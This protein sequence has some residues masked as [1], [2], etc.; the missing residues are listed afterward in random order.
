VSA[1]DGYGT[2]LRVAGFPRA[3][4]G[5]AVQRTGGQMLQVAIVLFVLARFHSPALAGLTVFLE[6]MPGLLISPL[7]GALLD[8]YGRVRLMLL[9]F[10][11]AAISLALIA[12]L[13]LAGHLAV[14]ALL[15]LVTISSLTSILSV[16]GIRSLF[17]LMVPKELWDRANGLDSGL[18]AVTAIVGPPL[19]AFIVALSGPETALLATAIAFAL[20]AAVMVGL[21]EPAPPERERRSIWREAYE[22]LRYVVGHPT[23]RGLA[24]SI[25]LSNIGAGG[26]LVI[27]LPVLLLSRL[28]TGTATVGWVFGVFGV[29][30]LISALAFGRMNTEG[31]ERP[32]LAWSM[33]TLA[34]S[35]LALAVAGALWVVFAATIFAGLFIGASDVSL[36]S[37]RQRRTDPAW[38][39]RAFAVSMSLNFMGMPIGSALTGA[40]I[41]RSITLAFLAGAALNL[42]AGL[43]AFLMIPASAD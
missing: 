15:A 12:V 4:V 26:T 40:L 1:G 30:S 27:A 16:T 14:G 25:S 29:A 43:T 17:P 35:L 33:V 32:M 34:I 37:I 28:H 41:Q 42:L 8:R 2:L 13:S 5:A 7:A 24:V 38:F 3:L 19:A 31:R 22:G 23:L 21:E 10:S 6:I 39:G 18:Y 36:F 9:D 20:A 11:V